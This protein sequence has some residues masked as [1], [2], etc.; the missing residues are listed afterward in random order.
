MTTDAGILPCT[1]RLTAVRSH[2]SAVSLLFLF[3]NIKLNRAAL[4]THKYKFTLP[5]TE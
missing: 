5:L 4:L 1:H 2:L 3:V